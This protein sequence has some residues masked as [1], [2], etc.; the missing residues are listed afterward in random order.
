MRKNL[1]QKCEPQRYS[2]GT[3]KKTKK[4]NKTKSL[5]SPEDWPRVMNI[6]CVLHLNS[7][8]PVMF[9]CQGNKTQPC[10]VQMTRLSPDI[11][12]AGIVNIKIDPQ[13]LS[14]LFSILG[15]VQLAWLIIFY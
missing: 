12:A 8:L 15:D 4:Q 2:W 9:H 6:W 14:A 1:T 5:R 10:S 7:V 3:Q 13:V 11:L